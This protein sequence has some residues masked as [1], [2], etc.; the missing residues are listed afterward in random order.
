MFIKYSDTGGGR[1]TSD[2]LFL[3]DPGSRVAVSGNSENFR[4][5]ELCS[6]LVV[7]LKGKFDSRGIFSGGSV[8]FARR[9]SGNCRRRAKRECWSCRVCVWAR[10]A[11]ERRCCCGGDWI[12]G[13]SEDERAAQVGAVVV[14]VNSMISDHLS[15]ADAFFASLASI[16]PVILFP[17]NSDPTYFALPQQP[18]HSA[19]FEQAKS[20]P[21][22][23]PAA[24]RSEHGNFRNIRRFLAIHQFVGFAKNF[25]LRF[26]RQEM[27]SASAVGRPGRRLGVLGAPGRGEMRGGAR[28]V[29]LHR[30]RVER[31][32][33]PTNFRRH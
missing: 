2:T 19:I 8:D 14:I 23:A 21:D 24:R 31:K 17:G 33:L 5:S 26:A 12:L 7:A 6:G 29:V 22:G 15:L 13:A 10:K 4:L 25:R 30:L 27:P 3:E 16:S 1:E 9:D 18:I 32:F 28:S 11:D 20:R